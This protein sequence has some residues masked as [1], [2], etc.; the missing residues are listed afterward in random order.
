MEQKVL[1][2]NLP[3]PPNYRVW[4]DTAG[5]FGTMVASSP[6]YL[7]DCEAPLHPF[8]T[9]LASTFSR[10][11]ILFEILDCQRLKLDKTETIRRVSKIN[12][13][14]ILSLISLPS[15][16]QD[17]LILCQIKLVL[18]NV[19]TLALGAVTQILSDEILAESN[20]SAIIRNQYPYIDGIEQLILS[21]GESSSNVASLLSKRLINFEAQNRAL[22]TEPIYDCIPLE[23]Y[24]SFK[25]SDG[26]RSPYVQIFESKG[27]SY[28]CMYCPY[29]YGYGCEPMFRSIKSVISEIEQLYRTHGIRVFSF[30]SQSF[31][32]NRKHAE[33]LC[34]EIISRKLD[35]QWFCCVRVNEID[36]ELIRL[37]KS[38]GCVR[39][40]FGVETG[41]AEILKIAKPGATL[42]MIRK[43][44]NVTKVFGV[45][46]QANVIL[47]WPLENKETISS[48]R[49]FVLELK[50]DILNLSYLT[51]YPGTPLFQMAQNR[52]LLLTKDW[53]KYT[54]QNVLIRT[55]LTPEYL[56]SSKRRIVREL[57]LQKMVDL[58][59]SL[60]HQKLERPSLYFKEGRFLLNKLAS[61]L[62]N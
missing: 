20:I 31:A 1:I 62:D 48:T 46:N 10:A 19:V 5:G 55:A 16:K 53:S 17:L 22:T 9:Y 58:P 42:S 28:G 35:I 32:S 25:G 51:P 3:S 38:A 49:K 23:G 61:P 54:S 37:M 13:N 33:N 4:R 36:A 7:A 57:S 59:F 60:I 45:S 11:G 14:I 34:K 6:N 27:C 40:H 8:I 24:Q 15:I 41:S 29:P 2:L 47:G 43:A 50:P 56:Y 30:K 44:F 52:S 26:I 18:E 12:P 39:I 21:I